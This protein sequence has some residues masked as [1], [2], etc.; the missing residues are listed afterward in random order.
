MGISNE[1]S[2][3][4]DLVE[5]AIYV[6]F[7]G[8]LAYL[9]SYTLFPLF[10][11]L[12]EFHGFLYIFSLPVIFV[13]SALSF[14]FHKYFKVQRKITWKAFVIISNSILVSILGISITYIFITG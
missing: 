12:N 10:F 4:V 8:L 9:L 1:E 5:K 6:F 11:E 3:Q 14:K 13:L 2:K 7:V